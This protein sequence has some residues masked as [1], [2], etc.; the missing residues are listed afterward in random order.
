MSTE[1]LFRA[2]LSCLP[3]HFIFRVTE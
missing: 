3:C 1:R 2:S